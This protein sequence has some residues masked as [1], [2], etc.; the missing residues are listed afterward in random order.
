[1]KVRK[2]RIESSDLAQL[3]LM[4]QGDILFLYTDG[5]YVGSDEDDQARIE[6]LLRQHEDHSAKE[7]CNAILNY[8]REKDKRLRQLNETDLIDDKTVFIIKRT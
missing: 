6:E 4:G 2:R 5:V 3:T 8:A 7:I 1:M